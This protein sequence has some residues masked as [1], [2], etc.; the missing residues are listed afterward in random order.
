MV[1]K[2]PLFQQL[3]ALPDFAPLGPAIWLSHPTGAAPAPQSGR[4]R[5]ARRSADDEPR[6]LHGAA[7]AGKTQA[8]HTPEFVIV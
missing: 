4:I 5:R 8:A 7:N 3:A 1:G 2:D 6:E